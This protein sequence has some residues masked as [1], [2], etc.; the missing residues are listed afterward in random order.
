MFKAAI[1]LLSGPQMGTEVFLGHLSTYQWLETDK[2]VRAPA[3]VVASGSWNAGWSHWPAPAWRMT[4]TSF[5]PLQEGHSPTATHSGDQHQPRAQ[6]TG[7]QE[8][9][10]R[11]RGM[12]ICQVWRCLTWETY[13]QE[14]VHNWVS[15][16]ADKEEEG[17]HSLGSALGWWPQ[18][19][20]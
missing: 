9:Y 10:G 4:N 3:A 2:S 1:Q 19:E 16:T 18:G 13:L 8:R 17:L 12:F 5:L 15:C 6:D 20:A 7:E 14:T 11:A